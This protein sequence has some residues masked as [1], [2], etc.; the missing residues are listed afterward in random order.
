MKIF[1]SA[2]ENQRDSKANGGKHA[3]EIMIENGVKMKW[4]LMSFY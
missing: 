1:L 3:A 2:I 4:N